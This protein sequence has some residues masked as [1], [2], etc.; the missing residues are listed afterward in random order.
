MYNC[1]FLASTSPC[2][3]RRRIV[4]SRPRFFSV[5]QGWDRNDPIAPGHR[6]TRC[7]SSGC[8]MAMLCT[9]KKNRKKKSQKNSRNNSRRLVRL[10]NRRGKTG[11]TR[12]A[13][14]G[15]SI[16]GDKCLVTARPWWSEDLKSCQH[17]RKTI[18]NMSRPM[19]N[20]KKDHQT[21]IKSTF[22][23][24]IHPVINKMSSLDPLCKSNVRS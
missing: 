12:I 5:C 2:Q 3:K 11:K 14:K 6:R 19:A 9:G 21:Q 1:W 22:L 7:F 20:R 8:S 15:G 18:E 23:I 13:R 10:Y 17:L 24:F 16:Q 4:P